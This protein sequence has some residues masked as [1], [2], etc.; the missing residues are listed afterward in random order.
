M[1]KWIALLLA[2]VMCFSL[3][4]CGGGNADNNGADTPYQDSG[5]DAK[6]KYADLIT[7]LDE[8]RYADA[9][10]E[11]ARMANETEDG[12]EADG[13]PIDADAAKKE[14]LEVLQGTWI[15]RNPKADKQ[16]EVKFNGNGTCQIDGTTYPMVAEDYFTTDNRAYQVGSEYRVNVYAEENGGWRLDLSHSTDQMN[17]N[18]VGQYL[19]LEDFDVVELTM[20]N[21]A[22]YFEF[23]ESAS[24]KYNAFN[25]YE[26]IQVS[27]IY[28]LK[29]EY[30]TRVMSSLSSAA[31]GYQRTLL[32][33]SF[34]CDPAAKIYAIG[35]TVKVQGSSDQ[36]EECRAFTLSSTGDRPFYGFI[37]GTGG[38][39]YGHDDQ[40]S[41]F[42]APP[43]LQR[44]V[45]TLYLYK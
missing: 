19:R 16:P 43:E 28:T 27:G 22:Q 12:G 1:K 17:W 13:A 5:K 21:A 39:G 37:V 15:Q 25:E 33:V 24:F 10:M 7:M 2:A 29:E 41:N 11:I 3:V 45:G 26:G 14:T 34:T 40:L 36:A 18:T 9:M 35:D 32:T 31:I 6:D 38:N 30:A 23:V 8:G 44:I 42:P 4:A 20:E